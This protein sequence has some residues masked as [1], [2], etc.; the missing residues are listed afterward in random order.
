MFVD[1]FIRRP[2]LASVC[3][4]VLDPGGRGRHSHDAGRAVP[5]PRV[6]AGQRHR[7]LH[8]SQRAGSRDGGHDTARAGHQRRRGHALHDL[9]EHEQR[10]RHDYRHLR[11]DPRS[12]CGGGGRAEPGQPDARAHA[13][14]GPD[15]RHHGP[16]AVDRL[17]H[18]GRRLLG[19]GRLRLALPEQLPRRLHQ[20]CRQ[21]RPGRRR[22]RRVRR[23]QVL[24]AALDRSGS[25]C[26]ARPDGRRR[27]PGTPRAERPGGG[28]KPR[29][30]AC[31][32]RPDVSAQRPCPRTAE[33][34]VGVREHHPQERTRRLARPA[35]GYRAA[36]SSARKP[37]L[38]TCA[39]R[40]SKRSASA[41][42][43]F[44]PPTRS[45]S[46]ARSR[47]NWIA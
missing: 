19:E 10:H 38:P 44:R 42:R 12:G 43:S 4:L 37:M 23:A 14:R 35:E 20:G 36:P 22:R 30:G 31:A 45:T 41:S 2:I 27:R 18:G 47:R 11:R 46:S 7:D 8:G 33:R 40:A 17:H 26:G 25:P 24:D 28:R 29:P 13:R 15:D 3:S 16:E 9:V 34:G 32:L 39:S 6:T 5:E 1:T 21:A